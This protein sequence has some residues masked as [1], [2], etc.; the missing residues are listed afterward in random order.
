MT[1][2]DCRTTVGAVH[3]PVNP[4][5]ATVSWLGYFAHRYKPLAL[6][7]SGLL[8]AFGSV[9]AGMSV[10]W[11][12]PPILLGVAIPAL[13]LYWERR[14]E[15][16]DALTSAREKVLEEALAPLLELAATTTFEPRDKRNEVAEGAAMRVAAD[17]RSAFSDV[18]DVRAVVFVVAPDGKEMKARYPAGRSDRPGDFQR[19]THRGDSA[20]RIVDELP[21]RFYIMDDLGENGSRSPYW[22]GSGTSYRTFISAPIRS[23]EHAFGMVTI[24]AP[25]PGSLDRRHGS[26]IALFAAALGILF[27]EAARGGSSGP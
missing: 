1:L 5:L 6:L 8:V 27:A 9:L 2:R 24:D 13:D 18:P 12:V 25:V 21:E 4:L 20:F 16:N 17:L 11:G 23:T 14:S 26:T 15:N 22:A 10:W 7:A 3:K 19:G